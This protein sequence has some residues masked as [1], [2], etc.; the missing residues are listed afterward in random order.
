MS[1]FYGSYVCL[2]KLKQ[3]VSFH[4]YMYVCILYLKSGQSK[5]PKIYKF[6]ISSVTIAVK[7]KVKVKKVFKHF[8]DNLMIFNF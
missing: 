1:D 4:L 6:T 8:V 2:S 7:K 5:N 3:S